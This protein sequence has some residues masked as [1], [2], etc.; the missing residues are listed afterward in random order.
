[1]PALE[2]RGI[3]AAKES[4]RQTPHL[5]TIRHM[6]NPIE[7]FLFQASIQPSA[8]AFQHLDS[9]TTYGQL[10]TLVRRT[11][12]KLRRSGIRPGHVVF[13]CLPK[14]PTLVVSLALF[15]EAAI[16]CANHGYGPID[17]GLA[18][19]F[20][21]SDKALP[22]FPADR[23]I[24]VNPQWQADLR[25]QPGDIEPIDYQSVQDDCRLILT[26]GSTGQS[27]AVAFSVTALVARMTNLLSYWVSGGVEV[28]LMP[29]STFAFV[30]ALARLSIGAT[31]Y[32]FAS[33]DSLIAG[34]RKFAVT[35][36]TGSPAQLTAL[37]RALKNG[38][39]TLPAMK[40]VRSGGAPL[41][42]TA[43]DLLRSQ[44]CPNIINF[45]GS[46]EV[47]GISAEP[48]RDVVGDVVT[49]GYRCPTAEIQVVDESGTALGAS[50]EGLIRTRSSDMAR[51]YFRNQEQTQEYF[52]EGWFYSGDRGYIRSDGILVLSGRESEVINCG[53]VKVDPVRVDQL[54]AADPHVTDAAVFPVENQWGMQSIAAALVVGKDFDL[55]ALRAKLL[56]AI[57]PA[58]T[59]TQFFRLEQIP[60]NEL[61]KAARARLA[62]VCRS[63][64]TLIP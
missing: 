42:Q 44:L 15:H 37:A 50:Q 17:Q 36:V 22:D 48:A 58:R 14:R 26:S 39:V 5:A 23:T 16:S 25:E 29:P 64:G 9:A 19:D 11:A 21:I 10:L 56:A 24:L 45:Y 18:V 52:R 6:I 38:S 51:G 12:G 32:L 7:Q 8:I 1:L 35:G 4:H 46:T 13:T 40:I 41:T 53:G 57:G 2:T 60:R 47:G 49:A 33:A 54:I 61:G 20:V 59:P 55:T 43:L 31:C 63:Q 34:L 28:D 3:I 30:A 62:E 27:K